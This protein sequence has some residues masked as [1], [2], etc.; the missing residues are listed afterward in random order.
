[1]K[2][3]TANKLF[4]SSLYQQIS[5]LENKYTDTPINQS[6]DDLCLITN[7][8]I[9]RK[10]NKVELLCGHI[11]KYEAIMNSVNYARYHSKKNKVYLKNNQL[12]C[13]YC[14]NIQNG[15][16]PYINSYK[17]IK[18]VNS[19][20]KYV[21]KNKKCKYIFK[22][23]KRKGNTCDIRCYHKYCNRCILK[24]E[25]NDILVKNKDEY[26]CCKEILK[27][28]KRKGESCGRK[29]KNGDKCGIHTKPTTNNLNTK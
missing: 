28:G 15:L 19:P 24:K 12:Q 9:G 17:R 21:M 16:L 20:D 23:G 4:F 6:E 26:V 14:R 2:K 27:T 18:Y 11:F 7:E 5:N 29:C 25:K 10:D 22:S 8:V 1:M 3:D 13:P